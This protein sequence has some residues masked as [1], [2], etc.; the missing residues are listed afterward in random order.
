MYTINLAQTFFSVWPIQSGKCL[1]KNWPCMAD[2][3]VLIWTYVCMTKRMEP[4]L[5]YLSSLAK[6]STISAATA[7]APASQHTMRS[8]L[9][10]I[11]CFL[12]NLIPFFLPVVLFLPAELKLLLLL[13]TFPLF[14]A[15]RSVVLYRKALRH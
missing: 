4:S 11:Q 14:L 10:G 1:R 9:T 8:P 2:L 15:A 7:A 3:I 6:H 13:P 5:I 12:N